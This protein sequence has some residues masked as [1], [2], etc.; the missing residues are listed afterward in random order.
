VQDGIGDAL[1][2]L[3]T[4]IVWV[5]DRDQ[6]PMDE[7]RGAVADGGA[8]VT[9]GNLRPQDDGSVQVSASIYVAMLAAGGQ[10]YVVEQ[11]NGVWEVTGTT[12]V[13]WMS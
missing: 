1:A 10:T 11:V 3:P 12:G 7:G 6:V 8:I 2:D 5:D 4:Q 9:L 13:I